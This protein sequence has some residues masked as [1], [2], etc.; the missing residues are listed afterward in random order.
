MAGW[1]VSSVGEM[2]VRLG[3]AR[4]SP[5]KE[6]GNTTTSSLGSG[7]SPVNVKIT[8]NVIFIRIDK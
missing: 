5:E 4:P 2:K 1:P 6:R 8:Y 7:Y 3:E